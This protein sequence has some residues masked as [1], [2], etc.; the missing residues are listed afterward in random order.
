MTPVNGALECRDMG[1]LGKTGKGDKKAVFP[2]R[3]MSSWST[4]SFTGNVWWFVQDVCTRW[5]Q[6]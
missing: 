1:S 6:S 2:S 5:L 3:P 4:Q